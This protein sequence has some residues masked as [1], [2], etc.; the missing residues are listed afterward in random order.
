MTLRQLV[1]VKKAGLDLPVIPVEEGSS[2]NKFVYFLT[3][4][5]FWPE[6][7]NIVTMSVNDQNILIRKCIECFQIYSMLDSLFETDIYANE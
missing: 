2:E 7:K 6:E 5:Q 3:L 4:T 1:S